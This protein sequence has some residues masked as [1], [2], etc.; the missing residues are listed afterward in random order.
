MSVKDYSTITELPNTE[1]ITDQLKRSF[2]RYMFA[3]SRIQS[4]KLVEIGCGGG[5]GL[6]LLLDIANKIVGYD[7]DGENIKICK[8]IYKNIEKI[9]FIAADVEKIKFEPNNIKTVLLFETIYYLNDHD[10]FFN[11]LNTA[12]QSDGKV[13]ICTANKNW[14]AFNPSPFSTKYFS[15]R[16]LYELGKKHSFDVE[17][18]SSFPDKPKNI[19][20]K[21]KNYVKRFAVRFGLIPRSMKAKLLFKKLFYG[22]MAVMPEKFEINTI[23]YIAPEKIISL[24]KDIYSTAIFAI[25]TKK[26]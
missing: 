18:F 2:Q 1:V 19:S 24:D 13:I 16:E 5:Q 23:D 9:E 14:H 25:F 3:R 8:N 11:N 22:E 10:R 6:N 15:T 4:G 17:M 26:S 7:I 21:M 20:D 12:L